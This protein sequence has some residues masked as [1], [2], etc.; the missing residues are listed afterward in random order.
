MKEQSVKYEAIKAHFKHL[1]QMQYAQW[2]CH[3]LW[4]M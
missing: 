1:N 2:Q 3:D 4:Y